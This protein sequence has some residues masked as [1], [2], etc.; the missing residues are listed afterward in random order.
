MTIPYGRM[1]SSSERLRREQLRTE[2]EAEAARLEA[3]RQQSQADARERTLA[4]A[5]AKRLA[6]AT[7]AE[8][9]RENLLSPEKIRRQREWLANHPDK[10]VQDFER[11]AWPQLR[12]NLEAQTE[13]T[14]IA[15]RKAELV[16]SGRYTRL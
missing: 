7:R 4:R 6:E 16:A 11:Y 1:I 5:A 9:A 14:T 13:A 2:A 8:V 12:A 10:S 15:D 3:E